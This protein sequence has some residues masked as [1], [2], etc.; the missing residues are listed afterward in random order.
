MYFT[1]SPYTIRHPALI[2]FEGRAAGA[3]DGVKVFFY[4]NLFHYLFKG[5]AVGH[6]RQ[7]NGADKNYGEPPGGTFFRQAGKQE[8]D[9]D[10]E[11]QQKKDQGGK[12][13]KDR[14]AQNK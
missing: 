9:I 10:D 4:I 14:C 3:K 7:G 5:N 8:T 6:K 11:K 12:D 13:I 2:P 1:L